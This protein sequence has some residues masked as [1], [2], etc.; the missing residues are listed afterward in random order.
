MFLKEWD[1]DLQGF[2]E[3]EYPD[4]II[5]SFVEFMRTNNQWQDH[6]DLVVDRYRH[7]QRELTDAHNAAALAKPPPACTTETATG[8]PCKIDKGIVDGR[9]HIHRRALVDVSML[10]EDPRPIVSIASLAPTPG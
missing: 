2:V 7:L 5:K 10:V 1:W 3:V 6:H 4:G 8:Q 9:C